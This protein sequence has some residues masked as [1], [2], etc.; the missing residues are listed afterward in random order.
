[1]G[2]AIVARN[3]IIYTPLLCTLGCFRTYIRLTKS[4]ID[5]W[6]AGSSVASSCL[7]ISLRKNLNLSP[8]VEMTLQIVLTRE[9]VK[10]SALIRLVPIISHDPRMVHAPRLDHT[11]HIFSYY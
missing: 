1:M 2:W 6:T 7:I 3:N 9:T 8:Y 4:L 10:Y 5:R 11:T